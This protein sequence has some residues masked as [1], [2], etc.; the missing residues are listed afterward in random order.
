VLETKK[1]E[2]ESEHKDNALTMQSIMDGVKTVQ[3]STG[4]T[5]DRAHATA[6][7]TQDQSHATAMKTQ[8]QTHSVAMKPKDKPKA[9]AAK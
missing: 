2:A 8:D 6:M 1:A 3:A 9:K 4:K 5:D 7:K